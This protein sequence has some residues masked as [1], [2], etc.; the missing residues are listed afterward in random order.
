M[1]YK[2]VLILIGLEKEEVVLWAKLRGCLPGVW[3]C[4][5]PQFFGLAACRAYLAVAAAA[6]RLRKH[7]RQNTGRPCVGLNGTVVSRPH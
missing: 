3:P 2:I 7:S 5:Q 1:E 4:P 6:L